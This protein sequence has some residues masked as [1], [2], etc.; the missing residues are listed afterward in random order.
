AAP[1]HAHSDCAARLNVPSRH[2]QKNKACRAILDRNRRCARQAPLTPT[3]QAAT[4]SRRVVLGLIVD[5][6]VLRLDDHD[7]L[8]ATRTETDKNPESRPAEF[9][10]ATGRL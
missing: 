3:P 5:P 2:D 7:R 6:R 1:T 9:P 4:R 10:L 8:A